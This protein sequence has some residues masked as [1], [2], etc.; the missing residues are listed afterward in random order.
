MTEEVIALGWEGRSLPLHTHVAFYY[1]DEEA[2]HAC[3]AFL[4]VGLDEPGTFSVLM[5]DAGQHASVLAELQRGYGGSVGR[6]CAEGRL[7]AVPLVEDFEAL[8]AMMRAAMDEVLAAGFQ[9]IRVLGLVGWGTPWYPDVAWLKRCEAEARRV[10]AEYPM[11]VVCL[12]DVPGV[13][14]EPFSS[15]LGGVRGP[16][17]VT[18]DA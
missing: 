9:R 3:L 11:V 4:R 12:Y 2:L 10:V 14:A 1:M 13:V 15:D 18:Y 8:A 16:V 17:I 5:A 6:A 7:R